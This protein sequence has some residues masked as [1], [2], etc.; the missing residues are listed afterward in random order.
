MIKL[1]PLKILSL[2]SLL[3]Y[4]YC[5]SIGSTSAQQPSNI[6]LTIYRLFNAREVELYNRQFPSSPQAF[7]QLFRE[8]PNGNVYPCSKDDTGDIN[9]QY[10]CTI[11]SSVPYNYDTSF[12][13]L[14]M[15]TYLLNVV[16]QEMKGVDFHPL[17]KQ[18]QAVSARSYANFKIQNNQIIDNSVANQAFIPNAFDFA[19]GIDPAD[20]IDA[21]SDA[22]VCQKTNLTSSQQDLC[23]AVGLDIYVS[24]P[25]NTL[26]IFSEFS[27]NA[28]DKTEKGDFSYLKSVD[29]PINTLTAT[30][31][32]HGRGLSQKGASRWA[33]GHESFKG[34]SDNPV[35]TAWPVR[36]RNV[37]QIL[38]HYYTGVVL[39]NIALPKATRRYL[40]ARLIN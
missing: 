13:T 2:C 28:K 7:G 38:H 29:E 12:V 6:S 17:A 14:S 34:Y 37:E 22:S 8:A 30:T 3:V 36:W 40:F 19:D 1:Y 24:Q 23:D 5:F 33:Y 20:G 27:D 39:C 9:I 25:Q 10:G 35:V 32:N 11:D 15:D 31:Q 18:A 26:S 16:A 4:T 21:E